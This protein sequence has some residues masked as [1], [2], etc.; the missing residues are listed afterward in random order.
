MSSEQ[1]SAIKE[2]ILIRAYEQWVDGNPFSDII[3][4]EFLLN[5]LEDELDREIDANDVKYTWKLM[6]ENGFFRQRGKSR[7]IWPKEVDKVE[8]LG[9][10]TKMDQSLQQEILAVLTD[11][12]R[13]NVDHPEVSR[14][15]LLSM[16]DAA[17]EVVDKNVWYVGRAGLAEVATYISAEPWHSVEIQPVGR[18]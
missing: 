6:T 14:E 10:E 8:A 9:I 11:A 12:E 16:L 5:D 4:R 13:Q 1:Q 2:T 3:H 7:R 18:Q 17:E 15:E